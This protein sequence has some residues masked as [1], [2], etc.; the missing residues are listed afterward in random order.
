TP[1]ATAMTAMTLDA[2]SGGRFRLGL[3]VSGP[4]VVEGWHGQAFG[5]PLG[6]T[7]EYVAIVRA[8]LRRDKPLAFSG[9]YYQI[10]YAGRDAAGL[11]KARRL[12]PPG[13]GA[14][15]DLPGGDRA[16]DRA[17][18][19]RDRRRLDPDDLLAAAHAALPRLARRRLSRARRR[20]PDVRHHAL[21]S[22]DR[23]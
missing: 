18:A 4:Q 22:G 21:V 11:G 3:G 2:L 13:R 9:E 1:A 10:P 7:R 8:I 17:P 19:R 6:K 20:P 15:A 23:R 12:H 5:K 14:F 16:E